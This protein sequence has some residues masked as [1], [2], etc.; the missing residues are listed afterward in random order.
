[1][2]IIPSIFRGPASATL[3]PLFLID[4]GTKKRSK[5]VNIIKTHRTPVGIS[6][7]AHA[8]RRPDCFFLFPSADE[9]DG[10]N[11]IECVGPECREAFFLR[12]KTPRDVPQ[13]I[14]EEDLCLI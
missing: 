7:S 11:E 2:E 1:M 3:E 5:Y 12:F 4:L 14:S 10:H 6:I 8:G 13:G 9:S